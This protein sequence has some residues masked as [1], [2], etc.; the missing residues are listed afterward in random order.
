[1]AFH[2]LPLSFHGRIRPL[3]TP[4]DLA[5]P[6][7][8]FHDLR[9]RRS[10]STAS[11]RTTS[12]LP[13]STRPAT[14][15][16]TSR[17]V[18]VVSGGSWWLPVAPGGFWWLLVAS[19]GSRWLLVASGGFWWLLVAS[20]GPWWLLMASGGFWW[21]LVA[22]GDFWRHDWW[23]LKKCLLLRQLQSPRI[24]SGRCTA[25][26]PTSTMSTCVL[27]STPPRTAGAARVSFTSSPLATRMAM[28]RIRSHGVAEHPLPLPL[29]SI[30]SPLH[31]SPCLSPQSHLRPP[32]P[33]FSGLRRHDAHALHDRGGLRRTRRPA[34][35]L[36][37]RRRGDLHQRARRRQ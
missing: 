12:R 30:S 26:S 35:Q 24:S 25:S 34:R 33:R 36:L 11:T 17:Y 29:H 21:L 20:G 19:G 16:G 5:R 3:T 6:P 32:P 27:F 22:S 14:T 15:G 37:D 28:A 1:M 4:H 9:H 18:L 23:D 13:R 7:M 31:R 2:V 10:A 8:I